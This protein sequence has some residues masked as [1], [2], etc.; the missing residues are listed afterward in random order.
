MASDQGNTTGLGNLHGFPDRVSAGTG[1]GWM[2][3]TCWKPIPAAQIAGNP[4][5]TCG[6]SGRSYKLVNTT[7]ESETT[8]S[9]SRTSCR[10]PDPPTNPPPERDLARTPIRRIRERKGDNAVPALALQ[11]RS[12]SQLLINLIINQRR[13]LRDRTSRYKRRTPR[14]S[15]VRDSLL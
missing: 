11:Q 5:P 1:T 13:M 15:W 2:S 7:A 9:H 6:Y 14:H 8:S 12:L 10:R 4:V 3:D